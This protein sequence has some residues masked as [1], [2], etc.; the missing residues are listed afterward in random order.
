[1]ATTRGGPAD[2]ALGLLEDLGY[3]SGVWVGP[4]ARRPGVAALAALALNTC[5][6]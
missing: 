3:S 5:W 4:F 2:R 1:M 6:P